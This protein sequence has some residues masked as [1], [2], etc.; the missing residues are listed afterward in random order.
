M[1][2]VGTSGWVYPHWRGRFYPPGLPASRWL[3]FLAAAFST[4]EVNATFYSLTTP[5]A[6]DRWRAVVP[7]EFLFALKGSRYITHMKQLRNVD[8]ALANFYSSGILRLGAQLGPVLWQLPP[9]LRFERSVAEEFFGRLPRDVRAAEKLARRHDARVAGRACLRA[10]DGRD[11][12]IRYALEARHPSWMEE[13][14]AA[15]L[16][17]H[18][19]A[20]V[21]ADTGG[22][23]PATGVQTTEALAYVRLHGPR[24]IYEGH[25]STGELEAWARRACGWAQSG[26]PVFVYF[27]NDRDAAAAQDARRL[28]ALVEDRAD[29]DGLDAGADRVEAFRAPRARPAHFAFRVRRA[30]RAGGRAR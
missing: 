27:D 4:V 26:T 23:H 29:P 28:A 19:I 10:P 3:E 22:E 13:E 25:Y 18:A 12:P 6:C 5:R 9:R 7:P 20:L 24:K 1:V 16:R 21:W 14:A 8:A 15:L 11:A 17:D 30:D 2:H